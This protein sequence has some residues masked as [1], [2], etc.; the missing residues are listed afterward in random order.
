MEQ[1]PDPGM[2]AM[3]TQTPTGVHPVM[4]LTHHH[5]AF[6]GFGG[7]DGE[8]FLLS[9]VQCKYMHPCILLSPAHLPFLFSPPPYQHQC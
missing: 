4:G 6:I 1:Y 2:P 9:I 3:A 7:G 5:C 8:D